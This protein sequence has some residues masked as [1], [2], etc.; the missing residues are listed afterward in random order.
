LHALTHTP[1]PLSTMGRDL[2]AD[3]AAFITAAAAG[4]HATALA[5]G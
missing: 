5:A 2:H 1:T 4:T 3:P